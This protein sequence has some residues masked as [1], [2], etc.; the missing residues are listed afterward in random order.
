MILKKK[1]WYTADQQTG[2]FLALALLINALDLGLIGEGLNRAYA[3]G[4]SAIF[5]CSACLISLLFKRVTHID[6]NYFFAIVAISFSYLFVFVLP[7]L[8]LGTHHF[9]IQLSKLITLFLLMLTLLCRP[10]VAISLLNSL[11]YIG[12][13][14]AL[15]AI[16]SLFF[17]INYNETIPVLEVVSSRSILFEQNVF[18]IFAYHLFAY[19][20]YVKK[21]LM[22]RIILSLAIFSSFY[23]TVWV[24]ALASSLVYSRLLISTLLLLVLVLGYFLYS[25]LLQVALKLHQV[26]GLT[27]RNELWSIGLQ[28]FLE[29]PL[30]GNGFSSIPVYALEAIGRESL[31]SYHNVVVDV[32]FASGLVGFISLLFVY[33]IF[34]SM[35]GKKNFII[36]AILLA[37][38]L[39]NTFFPFSPN[40]LGGFIA[41]FSAVAL[42]ERRS[43][44]L[45]GLKNVE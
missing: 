22:P 18:G 16:Y 41:A 11:L 23:R 3:Q 6:K 21:D 25:N 2:F 31:T 17:P 13:C 24:L 8:F 4:A 40:L 42:H 30:F 38:S 32:V 28:G 26:E 12:F 44:S 39:L 37:P 36:G 10:Q 20:L 15:I 5:I 33:L 34:F 27:G 35:I 1:H 43:K 14:V 9:F 29:K 7:E 19:C 45:K